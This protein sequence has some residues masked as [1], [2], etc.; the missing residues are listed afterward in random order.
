MSINLKR[1]RSILNVLIVILLAT[2]TIPALAQGMYPSPEDLKRA[3][4]IH[5]AEVY[6]RLSWTA[7]PENIRHDSLGDGVVHTPDAMADYYSDPDHPIPQPV[8]DWWKNQRHGGWWTVGPN[9]GVPYYWGGS[10][11]VAGL[12]LNRDIE[13]GGYFHEKLLSDNPRYPAG[14]VTTE[15]EPKTDPLTGALILDEDG[16]KIFVQ[17][18]DWSRVNGV[19]CVGLINNTWRIGTRAGMSATNEGGTPN[20]I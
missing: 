9:V 8:T 11:A 19:D 4:M 20:P 3:D 18:V 10:T 13:A 14:D 1:Q 16:R 12:G 15:W 2:L 7:R 17:K 5:I 6:A